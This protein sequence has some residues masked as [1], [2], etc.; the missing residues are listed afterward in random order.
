MA[1]LLVAVVVTP[2]VAVMVVVGMVV[3]KGVADFVRGVDANVAGRRVKIGILPADDDDICV[4]V[5][6]VDVDVVVCVKITLPLLMRLVRLLLLSLLQ[7][8]LMLL[9]L[10]IGVS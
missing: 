10:L 2:W 5:I 6:D 9:L 8:L 1:L 3:V 7:L 4:D